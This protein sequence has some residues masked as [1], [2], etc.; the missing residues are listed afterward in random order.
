M[1]KTFS[2]LALFLCT[3]VSAQFTPTGTSLTDNKY[4][5]GGLA[6]GYSSL[7]PPTFGT[8]KFMVNGN[9]VFN[10]NLGLGSWS[11]NE[12][13]ME[14]LHVKEGK[15][16]IGD[17]FEYYDNSPNHHYGI[18]SEGGIVIQPKDEWSHGADIQINR[19]NSFIQMAVASCDY[20]Y[21]NNSVEGDLVFRGFS[22]GNTASN[23]I[24]TNEGIG[25]IKFS[26]REMPWPNGSN[27]V[28]MVIDNTG[29][30]GIGTETPDAELAVNGLIHTKEV[31][32]D[33]QGWPDYVFEKTYELLTIEEVDKYIQKNGHLPNI[34]KASE[35]EENGLNLGEMN[36]K[37]MEKV[38]ELT[39]YIIQLKK[40]I[41][42]IKTKVN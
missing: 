14:A 40:E 32:V 1:K 6:L 26:T 20:C 5:N 18:K 38:E 10:G 39:L 29:K 2:I 9:G 13:P 22:S 28:R 23:L 24:I 36:K 33:L 15:I 27:Q 12:Y 16:M 41:E 35:V 37:L 34:P 25:K 8:N 3:L 31:K 7:L 17:Y 19:G 42:Q 21:S 30:V 11:M 4:R